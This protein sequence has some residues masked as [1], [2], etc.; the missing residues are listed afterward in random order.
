MGPR[1]SV[2]DTREAGTGPAR[3]TEGRLVIN[4]H[5]NALPFVENKYML[6]L[7]LMTDDFSGEFSELAE[8]SVVAARSSSDYAPYPAKS[9][10]VMVLPATTSV[11]F[12]AEYSDTRRR[13]R[14]ARVP[15]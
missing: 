5:I 7:F 14:T 15:G 9:R 3:F 12:D 11:T 1:V 13:D 2:I 4:V 10:G 8:F 6:G